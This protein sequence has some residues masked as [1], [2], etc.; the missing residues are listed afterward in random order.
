[1]KSLDK[2]IGCV[3]ATTRHS[4][5]VR[6]LSSNKCDCVEMASRITEGGA[7]VLRMRNFA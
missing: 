5:Q 3:V 2:G 1:M 4:I 6:P 7:S